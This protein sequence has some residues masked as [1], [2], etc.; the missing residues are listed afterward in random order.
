MRN[1]VA[2]GDVLSLVAPYTVTSGQGALS[3]VTFG[4]AT[5]DVANGAVG[6]FLT[7]GTVD[8]PKATGASTNVALGGLVYWDNAAR[9]AT[10]VASGNTKIG[11]LA[12]T[13]AAGTA[14]AAIR[15]RLVPTI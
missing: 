7:Q 5:T 14:D 6:Q 11:T 9:L 10:G 2:P 13:V 3:G 8:L 1:F 4:I 15:V 12:Q